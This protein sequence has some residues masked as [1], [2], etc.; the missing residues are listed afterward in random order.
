MIRF[1]GNDDETEGKAGKESRA[2]WQKQVQLAHMQ[3]V[4]SV[5]RNIEAG[6]ALCPLKRLFLTTRPGTLA[7]RLRV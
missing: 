3:P 6:E 2:A 1:I 4:A 7:Q 5:R